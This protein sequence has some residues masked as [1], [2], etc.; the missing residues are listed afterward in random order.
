MPSVKRLVTLAASLV[1]VSC[2]DSTGPGESVVVTITDR[3][4]PDIVTGDS[5]QVVL[6][7]GASL[8][9]KSTGA[10][11]IEW[12]DGVARVFPVNDD[13]HALDSVVLS[14]ASITA[15]WGQAGL[16]PSEELTSQ[17]IVSSLVPFTL[18][19]TFHYRLAGADASG[20][21]FVTVAIPC[22]PPAPDSPPPV[23]STFQLVSPIAEAGKPLIINYAASSGAG[24]WQ[25]LVH[26][27]GAC[28]GSARFV[29]SLR[30]SV[31]RQLSVMLPRDCQ[32]G[33]PL[34]VSV[35]ASDAA[36]RETAKPLGASPTVVDVTPPTIFLHQ[37]GVP[38]YTF[39]GDWFVGDAI[40]FSTV[41]NDNALLR[42]L[43][44]EVRPGGL[45]DS[46]AVTEP[47]LNRRSILVP[48]AWPDSFQLTFSLVDKAGNSTSFT[49]PGSFAKHLVAAGTTT[50]V[51]VLNA[52]VADFIVDEKR[53]VVWMLEPFPS[54]IAEYTLTGLTAMRIVLLPGGAGGLE[55]SASGDSLLIAAGNGIGIVD[56]TQAALPYSLVPVTLD[57]S[58]GQFMVTV[59]AATNGRVFV[60]TEN[61]QGAAMAM[62]EVT[63]ATG[64]RRDRLDAGTPGVLGRSL[65]RSYDHRVMVLSEGGQAQR[66]DVASDAFGA[67]DPLSG[68]GSPILDGGGNVVAVGNALHDGSFAFLRTLVGTCACYVT[69]ALSADGQTHY[70]QVGNTGVIRARV[71]DGG[72]IDVIR[73]PV[74]AEAI[75]VSADGHWLVT[76]QTVGAVTTVSAIHLP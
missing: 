33:Q 18:R 31:S 47:E 16:G 46:V 28:T 69:G 52:Q 36:L 64:A 27:S 58:A 75:K 19:L 71:S 66:Y 63:L 48:A 14:A 37:F 40:E 53:G 55:I 26:Y 3:H 42:W 8:R 61:R 20:G 49:Q 67:F 23:I 1:L 17:W 12:L 56:L 15:A 59:R 76:K 6:S 32:L 35:S 39:G 25:T 62:L 74:P 51:A 29:D 45:R 9:A 54:R 50:T 24:L 2:S 65:S 43:A 7:C 73:N 41:L 10:E 68:V 60:L 13:V 30:S 4:G 72:I 5:G 34:Q 22:A 57:T 38:D 21:G 44:W 11:R 70:R